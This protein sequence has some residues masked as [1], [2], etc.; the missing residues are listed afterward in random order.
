M[1]TIAANV[2]VGF[3]TI[4]MRSHANR[5]LYCRGD[6]AEQMILYDGV[7]K[8]SLERIVSLSNQKA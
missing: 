1:Q 6:Y 4:F 7:I 5:P 2:H 3:G 8:F